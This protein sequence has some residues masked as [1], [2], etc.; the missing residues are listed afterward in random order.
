V[1]GLGY[2]V[3]DHPNREVITLAEWQAVKEDETKEE[4]EENLVEDEEENQEEVAEEADKA[5][6]LILRQ[7][8]SSQR[9]EK[10]ERRENIFHSSA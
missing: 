1:S 8:L 5:E 3:A 4:K 10:E 6:M 7:A 2:I 9:G